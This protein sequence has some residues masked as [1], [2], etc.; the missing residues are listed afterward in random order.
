MLETATQEGY[1]EEVLKGK[2]TW[3]PSTYKQH[4]NK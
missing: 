1:R 2:I 3:R 4:V